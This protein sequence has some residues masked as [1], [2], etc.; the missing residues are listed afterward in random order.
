[1]SEVKKDNQFKK[2]FTKTETDSEA[3]PTEHSKTSDE[4]PN[5]TSNF[6]SITTVLTN[7]IYVTDDSLSETT[8][9]QK[10]SEAEVEY[11][12]SVITVDV[13]KKTVF[14][15][16]VTTT[17]SA[18]ATT[19]TSRVP[20][21]TNKLSVAE[22]LT[23]SK[24]RSFKTAI[25][26]FIIVFTVVTIVCMLGLIYFFRRK[27]KKNKLNN[28]E[29]LNFEVNPHRVGDKDLNL[30]LFR[31]RRQSSLLQ[32]IHYPSPESEASFADGPDNNHTNPYFYTTDD[33]C[34]FKLHP[35]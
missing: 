34:M 15:S 17:N 24:P 10:N 25:T 32:S 4:N 18:F 13:K 23:T 22:D 33:P 1:M 26:A 21:S 8:S 31:D 14:S 29:K 19:T 2:T 12:T 5:S 9:K 16:I 27:T 28:K 11:F 6:P 35:V 30:T 3:E 20:F 7:T